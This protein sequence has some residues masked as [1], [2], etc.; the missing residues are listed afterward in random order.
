MRT[1]TIR[2]PEHMPEVQPHDALDA[3]IAAAFDREAF[4]LQAND[5]VVCCQK[6][7]SK[8]ENRYVELDCVVP[9]TRALD[10][11][12]RCRKDP[13]FVELV[14]RESTEVLRCVPDVL[15]VRHRL[16]F[17]VANAGID[18]SNIEGGE[19]RALLLPENPD[20]SAQS[21]CTALQ[22]RFRVPLAV[23]ISDS[24]GRAWRNGV[25]GTCIGVSGLNPVLDLR[26]DR[27]RFGRALKVTQIAAADQIAATATQAM[28]EAGEGTP[29]AV[30][31]GIAPRY[32]AGPRGTS[33]LIRSVHEYLFK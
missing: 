19:K 22:A 18:Q 16:G 12:E 8:A 27:D 7:V 21:L 13:R 10:L 33:A 14:L 32:F 30:V 2:V 17:V 29:V 6:I 4:A 25:C 1:M 20:G 26:G 23:L 28:G 31:S 11:A 3:L 9:G 15:I 5:V 24:F